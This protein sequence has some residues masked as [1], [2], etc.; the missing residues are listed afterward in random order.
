MGFERVRARTVGFWGDWEG[1]GDDGL[2]IGCCGGD[3]WQCAVGVRTK[4]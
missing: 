2:D 1:R 4:G 3:I